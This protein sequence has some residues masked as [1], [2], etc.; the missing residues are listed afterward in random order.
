LTD[1]VL[2]T[3]ATGFI[4]SALC[5]A[6]VQEGRQVRA[7]HR[8]SSDL[9]AIQD[10]P[11][12]RFVGD[13]LDPESL[14]T[15]MAGV[16]LLFH[17]AAQAAYWREPQAVLRTAVD[18]TVNVMQAAAAGGVRRAVLTSSIAAMGVPEGDELLTEQHSFNLPA[19]RFPYGHAKRR[20]EIEAFKLA[21][22]GLEVMAVN[23][24]IVL[25]PGD[26]NQISGSMVIEAARGWGFFCIDGG[27]NYVH[28]QDVVMGHL[29]AA[30]VGQPGERYILGGENLTHREAF[31]ILADIVGRRPPWLK[32]PSWSIEP[33]ARMIEALQ[34]LMQLP[35]DAGQLRMSRLRLFCDLSKS[36]QE[37]KLP[38]ARPFRQAAQEAYA[39]Y[40]K[41]GILKD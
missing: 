18:G 13:I 19:H 32:I 41:Q 8:E 25:G 35:F 23:P 40:R 1:I 20:A 24:T 7:L 3:G 21:E 30:E 10:L 2:V 36:Q 33:A 34:P 14:T 26:L 16:N 38:E 9:S 28:I 31:A 5:R 22:G 37:L 6:L 15:C 11:L 27:A 12:E 4:G 29:A 17:A 39:W